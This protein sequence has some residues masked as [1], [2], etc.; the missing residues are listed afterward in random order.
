MRVITICI[1]ALSICSPLQG[2]QDI[3]VSNSRVA[4]VK[5]YNHG[6][7]VSRTCT[8]NVN[9]G[10]NKIVI[11]QLSPFIHPQTIQIS[12]SKDISIVTV[13][14]VKNYLAE[15]NN[16]A[17]VVAA[18]ATRQ[19]LLDSLQIMLDK[20]YVIDEQILFMQTNRNI[21]GTSGVEADQLDNVYDVYTEHITNLRQ[22]L[23]STEKIINGYRVQ[24]SAMDRQLAELLPVATDGEGNIV[25]ALNAVSKTISTINFSYFVDHVT[26]RPVYDLFANG[27]DE[28]MNLSLKAY[29]I[30]QT[31]EAWQ[32]TKISL[33]AGSPYHTGARPMLDPSFVDFVSYNKRKVGGYA[34]NES[35]VLGLYA[36][37]QRE[38]MFSVN[39]K[40]QNDQYKSVDG[41]DS[42]KSAEYIW[43][44]TADVTNNRM[45]YEY[46]L[47]L[48]QTLNSD[49][50]EYPLEVAKRDIKVNYSYICV[51]KL[52]NDVYLLAT[53]GSNEAVNLP[54]AEANLFIE[55][56]YMGSTFFNTNADE[57][58][59]SVTFGTDN[60]IVCDRKV[61]KQFTSKKFMSNNISRA[62]DVEINLYNNRNEHAV[63]TIEDQVPVSEN[64]SIKIET[65]A[66]DGALADSETG[67]LTWVIPMSPQEKV[68]KH[69]SYTI[70]YPK[71]RTINNQ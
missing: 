57:D 29:I 42:V 37:T 31:G 20:K 26:W 24:I 4:S 70:T 64:S 7:L 3:I 69:F 67:K 51:P 33:V 38:T 9:A 17:Q 41:T 8:V 25:I 21:G 56:N 39:G 12:G 32:Q 6:A 60:R 43:Y 27:I 35:T 36:N 18:K 45:N 71:G 62:Y 47:A 46:V 30:Q 49:G 40:M 66:T 58:S 44:N 55:N 65:V 14:F 61:V 54:P 28:S 63:V 50:E 1:L 10:L 22:R 34:N 11:Q 68:R 48:P 53:L 59:I 5:I 23:T 2:Q 16:N 19:I 52:T 13:N 15:S